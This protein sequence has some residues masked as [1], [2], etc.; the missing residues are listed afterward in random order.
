MQSVGLMAG[1]VLDERIRAREEACMRGGFYG[2]MLV[3]GVL[4]GSAELRAQNAGPAQTKE[5]TS[6]PASGAASERRIASNAQA[7]QATMSM[8]EIVERVF[9]REKEQIEI[10]AS[11]API[12]ETYIQEE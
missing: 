1:E 9:K 10:I 8:N 7:P 4:A 11:Y 12:I 2:L 5:G 3:A 6:A